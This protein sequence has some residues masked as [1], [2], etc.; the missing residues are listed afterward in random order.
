MAGGEEL[1]RVE[2]SVTNEVQALAS[3]LRTLFIDLEVSQARY[4]ARVHRD[5]GTVSRFLSGARIPPWAFVRDLLI[6]STLHHRGVPPTTEVVAHLQKLHRAAL[7]RGGSPSHRVQLLQDQ[8]AEADRRAQ[9]LASR[10]AKLEEQLQDA[11][12]RIAM[13]EV[14]H[15]ELEAVNDEMHAQHSTELAVKTTQNRGE[16]RALL[17]EIDQLKA[18]IKSAHEQRMLAEARCE[19]LER[20][21][22]EA[23]K[24]NERLDP[25]YEE[26]R[27]KAEEERSR[28]QQLERALLQ[29]QNQE[30]FLADIGDIPSGDQ[31]T[32]HSASKPLADAMGAALDEIE[33]LTGGRSQNISTGFHD[34][35]ALT[36]GGFRRGE[37]VVISSYPG[38]GKSIFGLNLLRTCSIHNGLTSALFA[39]QT[40]R[41]EIIRRLLCA[42]AQVAA[43][44]MTSGNMSSA[45]RANL[46]QRR[47]EIAAAPL[48]IS[49]EM[50]TLDSVRD[51]CRFLA[52]QHD[53]RLVVVDPVDLLEA[54]TAT[55]LGSRRQMLGISHELRLMAKDLGISVVAIAQ[56]VEPDAPRWHG[57]PNITDIRE[58]DALS[59]NAD[60]VIMIH[61]EDLRDRESPRAGEAD[62]IITKHRAGP[63][64]T[65]TTTFEG[66]FCRFVEWHGPDINKA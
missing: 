36:S 52:R 35:D 16:R 29:Y 41:S 66:H 47:T 3:E 57:T 43:F 54:A 42:E 4:A 30:R 14:A 1:D 12:R 2:P 7:E 22:G 13:F 65:I 34:L 5:K 28:A 21:L 60:I 9:R 48:F 46:V 15:R 19:D 18:E 51:Q 44:R 23:V 56:M 32:V 6:E 45:E 50:E 8:L 49:E 39:G 17:D 62:L 40:S 59:Q 37:L 58:S 11:Q 61:R 27:L 63:T 10:E 26:L 20:R 25:R 64:A 53:L 31:L 33:E 24:E 38:A 55:T